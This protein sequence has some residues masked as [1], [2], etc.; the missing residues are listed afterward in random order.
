MS[1]DTPGAPTREAAYDEHIAPLMAEVIAVCKRENLPVFACFYL[2]P[3]LDGDIL[4]CSTLLTID[5]TRA[6]AREEIGNCNAVVR[7]GARVKT[8]LEETML[9][10]YKRQLARGEE[11]HP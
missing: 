11:P 5:D 7:V 8:G 3:T 2:D 6:Q 10:A 4:K 9:H 1:T